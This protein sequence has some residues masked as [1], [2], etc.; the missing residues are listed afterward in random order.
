[1]PEYVNGKAIK[2]FVSKDGKRRLHIVA[3]FDGMFQFM[4]DV[5]EFDNTKTYWFPIGQSGLYEN[6]ELAE[7]EARR[8]VSWLAEL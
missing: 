3:R 6:V 2:A 8:E 5:Q 7:R 1:M 4:E